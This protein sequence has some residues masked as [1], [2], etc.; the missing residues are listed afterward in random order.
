MCYNPGGGRKQT[1]KLFFN[2]GLCV[3]SVG[4]DLCEITEGVRCYR[5]I[6]QLSD[7]LHTE[8]AL[9]HEAS[10]SEVSSGWRGQ[11]CNS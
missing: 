1:L 10:G 5:A 7:H 8:R 11:K 9:E 6:A 3:G 2:L 4:L